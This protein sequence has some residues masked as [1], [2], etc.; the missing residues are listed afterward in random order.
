VNSRYDAV[1]LIGFGGPT[2]ADE[3]RPFLNKVLNGRPVAPARYEEVVHHYERM[4][5]RSPYNEHVEKQA[6]ALR[7]QL[8]GRKAEIPVHVGMRNWAPQLEQAIAEITKS[9]ARRVFGFVLAPH[10]CE[11]SWD[12]Y[13]ASVDQAIQKTGT[14]ELTI[15]YPSP[16]HDDPRFIGAWSERLRASIARLDDGGRSRAEI[17]FTAHSIP[18]AM[19]TASPYVEQ[20]NESSRLVAQALNW[21]DWSISYQSRSGSARE[22]WLGPEIAEVL[23]TIGRPAIVAPIGFVCDHVEVLYDLDVEAAMIARESGIKMV[24][25]QTVGDHPKFIEMIASMV[26]N[27]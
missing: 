9:G 18:V 2:R 27:E 5:G 11:A 6:A 12:R 8:K 21:K 17:V 10:R 26:T 16:W 3:V 13:I 22:P 24:R 15:D 7:K 1:L 14:R 23:K 20:L 4:G 25:A 19:A